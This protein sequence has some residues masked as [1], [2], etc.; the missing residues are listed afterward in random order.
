[1]STDLLLKFG[2]GLSPE[3][4]GSALAALVSSRG[5]PVPRLGPPDKRNRL[6]G[7]LG[8][9]PY[10]EYSQPA[11]GL[12]WAKAWEQFLAEHAHPTTRAEPAFALDISVPHHT[13]I[14]V[15][16][17]WLAE[18]L[19]QGRG[20]ASVSYVTAPEP[21]PCEWLWPLDVGLL[22]DR[23]AERLR[24]ELEKVSWREFIQVVEAES[25]T[26]P[27]EVL[28]LPYSLREAL[29]RLL[30]VRSLPRVEVVVLLGGTGSLP[31]PVTMM[32]ALR[33]AARADA[34]C[35][36]SVPRDHWQTFVGTVLRGLSHDLDFDVAV[37]QACRE[38]KEL[39]PLFAGAATTFA[40]AHVSRWAA[41]VGRQFA[42]ASYQARP[43]NLRMASLRNAGD[44]GLEVLRGIPNF[45]WEHESDE[46]SDVMN[47]GR[48]L[49]DGQ[50]QPAGS[51]RW[52]QARVL[53]SDAD[54]RVVERGPLAPAHRYNLDVWIGPPTEQAICAP[55]PFPEEVLPPMKDGLW[56]TVVLT[57]PAVRA[58]PQV[59]R[60][61]LPKKEASKP[62]RFDL[63][64]RKG[65][66]ALEARITVLHENRVV[67]TLLLKAGVGARARREITLQMEAVIRRN[68]Q[69]LGG[70]P[71]FDAALLFNDTGSTPTMTAYA[72]EH[73]SMVQTDTI[74]Q[75]L[76]QIATILENATNQPEKYGAPS[77]KAT[78]RLL[79]ELARQGRLLR[80]ALLLD[81][82]GVR[83]DLEH[84]ERI[85]IIAAKPERVLPLE[86]CYDADAPGR[87]A[88]MCPRWK[89]ALEQGE[90]DQKP[91]SQDQSQSVCPVAFWATSR[92]IERHTYRKED[93]G[94]LGPSDFALLT[95][96]AANGSR[97]RRLT[98]ALCA[99]AKQARAKQPEAVNNAFAVI[100][101]ATGSSK[102]VSCWEDWKEEVK[103]LP[104]LLVLLAHTEVQETVNA[105][106]IGDKQ[107]T[108]LTDITSK[109]GFVTSDPKQQPLLL[110]LGCS[111]ATHAR[112][113]Q[114]FIT[115][116]RRAGASIIV[117][118]LCE[119]LGRHA[120][121]I[122]KGLTEKLCAAN[123]SPVGKPMGSLM[124]EVRRE[125]LAAGYP[126]VLAVAAFGDADWLV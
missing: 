22:G 81:M 46:A 114:S 85:Q 30:K 60:L 115:Q 33:S 96:P 55:E 93:A 50:T 16:M 120:A 12:E 109:S 14:P 116:F 97:L 5:W 104:P 108:L 31:D 99:A 19:Q 28:M 87:G 39:P 91:C 8:V 26:M 34:V 35:M 71:R 72:D 2:R 89:E 101:R 52:V 92:V 9:F 57:A 32:E 113:F 38:G 64:P 75:Y 126:I 17:V 11:A 84:A 24:K 36:T 112:A 69:A 61:W 118:T 68:L 48:T 94:R 65:V 83:D 100:Q 40:Q 88:T 59:S 111:T 4:L 117:G 76:Q 21:I 13:Y 56:L 95:E 47:L 15:S 78:T 107:V 41:S 66:R 122:A 6:Q 77:S 73:A 86:F 20:V 37:T 98:S 90:C 27:I 25:A 18:K 121:P 79:A 62:V 44:I 63:T 1:M 49:R 82:P 45:R 23:E 80:D 51:P 54:S 42:R 3:Q 43:A 106:V 123:S 10:L 103:K 7:N 105:L 58:E 125:M 70:R 110:L 119:I 74:D 67:Q 124:R 29:T 53:D 102:E